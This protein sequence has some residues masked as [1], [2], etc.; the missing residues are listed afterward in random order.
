[1]VLRKVNI[2]IVKFKRLVMSVW[3]WSGLKFK[4]SPPLTPI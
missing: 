3:A 1:M 2:L 4:A